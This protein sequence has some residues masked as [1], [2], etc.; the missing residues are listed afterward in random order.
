MHCPHSWWSLHRVSGV[1]I[2]A[3]ARD[4]V[5]YVRVG[6]LQSVPGL[7]LCWIRDKNSN[8]VYKVNSDSGAKKVKLRVNFVF[9]RK[10]ETM[11]CFYSIKKECDKTLL[12]LLLVFYKLILQVVKILTLLLYRFIMSCDLSKKHKSKANKTITHDEKYPYSNDKWEVLTI[13]PFKWT[14][15]I[16]VWF[17]NF[18]CRIPIRQIPSIIL[19]FYIIVYKGL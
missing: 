13:K 12:N 3:V 14:G 15:F 11:Y 18:K 8:V 17:S 6:I 2:P 1:R 4:V 16:L 10:L 9:T 19:N 5:R 7:L